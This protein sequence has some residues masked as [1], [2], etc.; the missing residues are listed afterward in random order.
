[1]KEHFNYNRQIISSLQGTCISS[2]H[3][4][5]DFRWVEN[6]PAYYN[7]YIHQFWGANLIIWYF[8]GNDHYTLRLYCLDNGRFVTIENGEDKMSWYGVRSI[9]VKTNEDLLFFKHG[10]IQVRKPRLSGCGIDG[11]GVVQR[12]QL[13]QEIRED[14][15]RSGKPVYPKFNDNSYFPDRIVIETENMYAVIRAEED[16]D[17][18]LLIKCRFGKIDNTDQYYASQYDDREGYKHVLIEEL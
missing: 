6:I 7:P 18:N 4:V 12:I 16:Y 17:Q 15:Y 11:I 2:F 10:S 14:L 3:Y 8:K 13:Y 1:M 9:G 5:E